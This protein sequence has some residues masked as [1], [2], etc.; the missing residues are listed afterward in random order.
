MNHNRLIKISKY[1]SY[2]LRHRPEKIGLTLQS[3]GWVS[4]NEL[5]IAAAK[6]NFLMTLIELQEVVSNNDK[7]RFSFDETG[8]LIRANQGHSVKIDL[9][10]DPQEPPSLLYHGTGQKNVVSI[11]NQGLCKM[12]RHHVHLSSNIETARSVGARHG[13]P[14]VFTINA[15]AMYNNGYRFYCSE[16]GV[17]L[18]DFVPREYIEI[19]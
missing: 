17:W 10:L 11:L 4:V 15:N 5:L 9:Q 14:V 13:I 7:K 8:S 1:L 3:G 2:H 16:N 6:D 12:G 18:V 19:K